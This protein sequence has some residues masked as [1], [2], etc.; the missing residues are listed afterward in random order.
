MGEK[1]Y[2]SVSEASRANDYEDGC[3]L[4][5]HAACIVDHGRHDGESHMKSVKVEKFDY[6]NAG[7]EARQRWYCTAHCPLR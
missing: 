2:T 5:G 4:A 6:S 3:A 1:E 7:T